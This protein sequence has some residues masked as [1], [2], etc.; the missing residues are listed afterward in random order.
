MSIKSTVLFGLMTINTLNPDV[1]ATL[2][3]GKEVSICGNIGMASYWSDYPEL[4]KGWV[5]Y[6]KMHLNKPVSISQSGDGAFPAQQGLKL[7]GLEV[8]SANIFKLLRT[9]I[10]KEICLSGKLYY[11]TAGR[12]SPYAPKVFFMVERISGKAAATATAYD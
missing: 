2:S 11:I 8:P 4:R 9:K 12:F 1:G 10:N 6:F 7:I 3:Y 5:D